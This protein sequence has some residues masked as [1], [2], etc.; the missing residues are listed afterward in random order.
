MPPRAPNPTPMPRPP[1]GLSGVELSRWVIDS[2]TRS[3]SSGGLGF[4]VAGVCGAA[5][6]DARDTAI[7]STWLAEGMQGS[8]AYM[9]QQIAERLDPQRVLA[10]ARCVL[11]VADRYSPRDSG[12]DGAA[13]AE[14]AADTEP[15]ARVARYARGRDYHTVIKRRLHR[16]ADALRGAFPNERFVSFTD[17]AP[18]F[19]RRYAQKAGLGWLAKNAML[20]HPVH[21]SYLLLGGFLTTLDLPAPPPP[22]QEVFTDHCGTCTRCI[23]A[24]PTG[25]IARQPLD[26]GHEPRPRINASRCISYLTIEHE[27]HIDTPLSSSMGDWAFG[28][29]IC[30]EVCPHNSARTGTPEPIRHEYAPARATLP[31]QEMLGWQSADRSRLTVSSMKRATAEMFRRNAV[32]SLA[33]RYLVVPDPAVL[34]AL[35]RATQDESPLVKRTAVEAIERIERGHAR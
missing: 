25:A 13:D 14:R 32:L 24:C 17:T 12:M 35:Q 27:G 23:D 29:D 10:G 7:A 20:I 15:R 6:I 19:E 4:T 21:G 34:S 28:C 30:Q 26:G 2:C 1:V 3:E 22:E 8:M 5:A 33:N 11:M 31:L 18:V 16:L 9:Q